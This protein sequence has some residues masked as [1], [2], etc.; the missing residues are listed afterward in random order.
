MSWSSSRRFTEHTQRQPEPPIVRGDRRDGSRRPAT[1]RACALRHRSA[2]GKPRGGRGSRLH[3]LGAVPWGFSLRST[4]KRRLSDIAF[5]GPYPDHEHMFAAVSGRSICATACRSASRPTQRA[6]P[7]SAACPSQRPVGST[8]RASRVARRA[9]RRRT[10]AARTRPRVMD[11]RP[12]CG[13]WKLIWR[14][15]TWA[16]GRTRPRRGYSAHMADSDTTEFET[17]RFRRSAAERIAEPR[18]PAGRAR[19]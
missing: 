13:R 19:L 14:A 9:Y 16:A 18:F 17:S 3:R 12:P 8:P 5:F 15:W 10:S 11:T 1:R 6:L 2:R 7:A 4:H